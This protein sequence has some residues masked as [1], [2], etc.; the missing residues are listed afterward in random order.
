MVVCF[1]SKMKESKTKAAV[2]TEEDKIK[3]HDSA[4]EQSGL[5]LG[6]F[7]GGEIEQYEEVAAAPYVLS[8]ARWAQCCFCC[9]RILQQKH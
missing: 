2:C 8:G 7:W 4:A 9:A 5:S 1:C 3:G 6:F